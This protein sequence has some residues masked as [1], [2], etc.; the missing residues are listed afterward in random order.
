[1]NAPFVR[2][3]LAV[4]ALAVLAA[5]EGVTGPTPELRITPDEPAYVSGG[6]AT[7]TVRN[8]GG[9]VLFYNLCPTI[10]ERREGLGWVSLNYEALQ[11]CN[12]ALFQLQPGE[13]VTQQVVLPTVSGTGTYR[14]VFPY[15]STSASDL[16]GL[17]REWKA[18]QPFTVSGMVAF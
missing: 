8:L 16:D 14:I 4:A 13:S 2:R 1:M 11:L 15:I 6:T 7:L 9:E 17:P 5:C 10:V 18:S 3:F 12:A